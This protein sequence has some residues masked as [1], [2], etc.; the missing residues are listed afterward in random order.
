MNYTLIFI[1]FSILAI[2]FGLIIHEF[3]HFVF[4][5]IFKVD[6]KEFSIGVGP[7]IFSK[8]I[9]NTVFTWRIFPVMAYVLI[10]RNKLL[11]LYDEWK[12][13]AKNDLDKFYL[14][15]KN[16]L[17]NQQNK[18]AN[19]F[20]FKKYSK[21]KK[22]YEKYNELLIVPTNSV[23]L[24]KISL[25]KQL[26]IFFGGISVNLIAFLFFYT[27][28]NFA[29]ESRIN[30]FFQIREMFINIGKNLVFYNAW[31]VGNKSIGTLIGAGIR[32]HSINPPAS[33]LVSLIVNYFA[34]YNFALFLF[35]VLPIP[36]LDGFKVVVSI[37]EKKK[38]IPKKIE[39]TLQ[40]I[41]ISFLVYIF[42]SSII[43]DLIRR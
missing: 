4:A 14:Q 21:L 10:T 13:D 16:I 31:G 15:N 24:D 42:L 19:F 6:V 11:S 18:K 22:E 9:K 43:A 1:L 37:I 26:I 2:F 33:D 30:L 36:P 3:G 32:F 25:W 12:N 38:E 28:Y 17:D 41:G 40:I 23:V 5:K 20:I 35:N 29:F 8:K 27:I 39:N 7:K 34:I